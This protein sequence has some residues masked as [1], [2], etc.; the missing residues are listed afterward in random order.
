MKFRMNFFSK[1]S[2]MQKNYL[3]ILLKEKEGV[4]FLL[5]LNINGTNILVEERFVF[6]NG[7]DNLIEDVDEVLYKLELKGYKT[8]DDVIFF[9]YS[10]AIDKYK[11][12][13]K[14]DYLLKIKDLVK[15]LE[16]K[17][18]GYI[19][20]QEA[21]AN[22]VEKRDKTPLSSI[23]IELSKTTL[24]LF[25]YKNS[26]M[27]YSEQVQRTQNIINDTA[28]LFEKIKT[29]SSI[30]SRIVIYDGKEIDVEVADIISR[31]WTK[32]LFIHPPK[33]DVIKEE[34]IIESMI[35]IF[36][37]KMLIK[38]EQQIV[39]T[40]KKQV[41]GFL[42]N[43]DI[44]KHQIED[45]E[46]YK[47]DMDIN[48]EPFINKYTQ[49]IR[50]YISSFSLFF[51]NIFNK[52]SSIK[53]AKNLLLIIGLF[54]IVAGFI[55]IEYFFHKADVTLF[56]KSQIIKKDLQINDLE[57]YDSKVTVPVTIS[58]KTTGKKETGEKAKG[59]V[60]IHNFD[61]VEKTF[62]KGTTLKSG[63]LAYLT[64]D[65]VKVASASLTS[66]SS[67][68]LPG[69][70]K[71]KIT[72]QNIGSSFNLEANKKFSIE[73]LSE[74][75]Y[76]AI[77][78]NPIS[79]GS[80]K[81][82][83]VVSKNDIESLQEQAIKQGEKK[84]GKNSVLKLQKGHL[85]IKK[86]LKID[87]VSAT[88]N[89]EVGEEAEGV[90]LKGNIKIT[91]KYYKEKE[92]IDKIAK[93]IDKE[94][95]LNYSLQKEN[96]IYEIVKAVEKGENIILTIKTN[97]KALEKINFQD[98]QNEMQGKKASGME[99]LIHEKF[100]SA[101]IEYEISHPIPLLRNRFPFFEKNINIKI[102]HE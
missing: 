3:G 54:F 15:N 38:E 96:L 62:E 49:V 56:V 2:E 21:V 58:K 91:F 45:T 28:P 93:N 35:D 42:I 5:K 48:R 61:S 14:K 10:F 25:F 22:L 65:N 40:E 66:D 50:S 17:P 51:K 67:A 44:D 89:K 84:A 75:D 90:T 37:R 68:K 19:E 11:R 16:L 12:D 29:E 77:N 70:N 32:N 78:E 87:L 18:L 8:P 60:T 20:A 41:M 55:L 34:E 73:D 95:K 43:E 85:P 80:K 39:Q 82:V 72:A 88:Y 86:L 1:K 52:I 92:L 13:I 9:V 100:K 57:I 46:R 33:I 99:E 79:G 97:A 102:S 69:K 7:W 4:I 6:S 63:D 31:G 24:T 83:V 36:S 23:L 81:E 53:Y 101:G 98:I 71:I 30:P 47:E 94:V 26:S 27:L 59:E 76:F 74:T 64:E